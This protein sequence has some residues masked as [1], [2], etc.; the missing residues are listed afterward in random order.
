M[1]YPNLESCIYD[2]DVVHCIDI[3]C[4]N[5]VH[6]AQINEMCN[7]IIINCLSVNAESISRTRPQCKTLP[8]WNDEEK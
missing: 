4:N 1:L 8:G 2:Y 6:G 7:T 3:H 5:D